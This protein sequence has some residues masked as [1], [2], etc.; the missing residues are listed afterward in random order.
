MSDA[1]PSPGA[2]GER[3]MRQVVA[4]DF[5]L[6]EAVGGWRGLVESVA[7]GL[8]FVV[9]YVATHS[10]APALVASLGVAL[11]AVVVRLA[12]RSPLT[13]ALGG[14]AGVA[15]GVVWAWRTGQAED[16]FAWGLITNAIFAAGVLVSILARRPVVG[17]VV[18]AFRQ[19]PRTWYTD[20]ALRR[21]FTIASWLWFALFAA[22]LAVQVPLYGRGDVAWLGTA[23]L[24]MGVPLWALTLWLTWILVRGTRAPAARPAPPSRPT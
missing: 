18:A 10:I 15:I 13:Q 3:G 23:R 17:A 14:T 16:F 8:V 1:T 19:E 24:V 22:R 4:A 2:P 5:S 7:P 11:V 9:A 20:P 6:A 21:R 12:Q